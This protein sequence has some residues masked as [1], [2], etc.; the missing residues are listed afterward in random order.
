MAAVS[1]KHKGPPEPAAGNAP[2]PARR[3]RPVNRE[4]SS[5]QLVRVLVHEEIHHRPE[6]FAQFFASPKSVHGELHIFSWA[7]ATLL[8]L[9]RMV[10]EVDV[11]ARKPGAKLSFMHAGRD[12][13]GRPVAK[14]VGVVHSDRSA[15]DDVMTLADCDWV[16]GDF[17]DIAIV[18]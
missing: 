2:P 11:R 18:S 10:Q 12:Q 1:A 14:V 8:E 15:V 6:E 7:D 17:I 9:T 5:P 4:M 13:K 16:A 3:R